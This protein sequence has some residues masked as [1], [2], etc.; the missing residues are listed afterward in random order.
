MIVTSMCQYSLGL[1]TQ[2]QRA[3]A[4][5]PIVLR[6]NH[7]PHIP[8]VGNLFDGDL[9]RRCM[10][11]TRTI[12]QRAILGALVPIVIPGSGQPQHPEGHGKRDCLLGVRHGVQNG[13]FSGAVWHSLG[14]ETETREAHEEEG[15]ADDGKEKH[16]SALK[17]EDLGL[18]FV[19]V[20]SKD[21]GR[22]D[23]ALAAA[24]PACSSGAWY[25]E[26][27]EQ[28]WVTFFADE[29]AKSVVIGTTTGQG[30][31]ALKLGTPELRGKSAH[32]QFLLQFHR[33]CICTHENPECPNS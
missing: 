13:A 26:V 32:G 6:D 7:I 5:L 1:S 9:R 23:R 14:V 31:H 33:C 15:Q 12:V 11:A 19:L 25:T 2:S 4:H 17:G 30:W 18:E 3:D 16:N 22:D 20:Q 28:H 10:W 24:N 29:I 21:L 8:H 27:M